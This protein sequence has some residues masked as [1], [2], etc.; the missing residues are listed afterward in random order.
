MQGEL[1]P[2][3]MAVMGVL[4]GIL[5]SLV[6]PIAV[7]TLRSAATTLESNEQPTVWERVISAWEQYN[8]PQ[9]FKIFLAAVFV[10]VVLVFLLDLKFYGLREAILAGFAWESLVNK[11]FGQQ[12]MTKS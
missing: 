11:L 4:M 12:G 7:N 2:N 10:A 8:G 1:L 5:I 3:M 6:L 9:Y